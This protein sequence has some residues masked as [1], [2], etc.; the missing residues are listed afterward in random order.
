V[1]PV[2]RRTREKKPRRMA[3]AEGVHAYLAN[4][5]ATPPPR[6][7]FP[8]EHRHLVGT[9]LGQPGCRHVRRGN[10]GS[11]PMPL[12]PVPC[13][14][15]PARILRGFSF[16]LIAARRLAGLASRSHRMVFVMTMTCCSM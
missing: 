3:E 10:F 16:G 2:D 6:G 1:R 9:D 4:R 11:P 13:L 8:A 5:G 7:R 14:G 15:S 12:S